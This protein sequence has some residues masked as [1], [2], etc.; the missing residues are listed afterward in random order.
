VAERGYAPA[1]RDVPG[2]LVAVADPDPERCARVA[3][4]VPR[5]ASAA[6]L[7]EAA[8]IDLLVVAS[9]TAFH[10][11]DARA[12][13]RR[14]VRALVEKP[15]AESADAARELTLLDPP[16]W[17]GFNRRFEP[18]HERLRRVLRARVEPVELELRLTMQRRRWSP[19]VSRDGPL[20]DLG[21]HAVDLAAW[22]TGRRVERARSR[23]SR[24]GDHAF[25]LELQDGSATVFVSHDRQWHEQLVARAG[26][27]PI[28]SFAVGGTL[29]R[30]RARLGIANGS[31]LPE[32]LLRQ[33]LAA[34]A[35]L[36]GEPPTVL[37]TAREGHATMTVLDAV[38]ASERS[39]GAW[40]SV[41]SPEEAPCSP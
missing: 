34:Q 30:L 4:D 39:G 10:V 36:R 12:A 26:G 27:T 25:D 8:S 24:D 38:R 21:T 33:L 9:P 2:L 23:E 14:G 11:E 6:E 28:A 37:A 20:L 7:L 35:A 32:L 15:P 3:P 5:Y 18:H 1:L 17:I 40:V 31:T 29:G 13:A 19:Y 16:P 41:A 22:I